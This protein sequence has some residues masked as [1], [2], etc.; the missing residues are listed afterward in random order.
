[1]NVDLSLLYLAC[2]D[3][4]ACL[5]DYEVSGN[6]PEMAAATLGAYNDFMDSEMAI[7]KSTCAMCQ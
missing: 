2:E 7:E 3:V 5:Y 4:D 6:D 1:M